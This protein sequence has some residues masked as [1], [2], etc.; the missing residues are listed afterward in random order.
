MSPISGKRP[1][2]NFFVDNNCHSL[3]GQRRTHEGK[4]KVK[5]WDPTKRKEWNA[6]SGN[7]IKRTLSSKK[8]LEV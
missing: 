1:L 2:S 5:Q 3:P 7:M 6:L 4:G 8:I